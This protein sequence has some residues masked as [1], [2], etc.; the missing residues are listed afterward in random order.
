MRHWV[1]TML[2]LAA[3]CGALAL[4]KY[5]PVEANAPKQQPGPPLPTVTGTPSGPIVTANSDEPQYN[6]RSGPG[7]FYPKIGFLLAGQTAVAK[8]RTPQGEWILIDYQGVA[9]GVGWVYS[10]NLT[11]PPGSGNIPIVEPP[12]T[13][14]PLYTATID[15]TLAAQFI[16]TPVPTRLPTFTP[17][18][19]LAIPTYNAGTKANGAGGGIPVGM[20]IIT[21]GSLGIF[22]GF[23]SLLRGR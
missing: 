9:G 10:P 3:L 11:I 4:A 6:V 17:P 20:V 12:P 13:P 19:P 21:L 15:P 5:I 8:G 2:I 22:L 7:I 14:T 18:P 1:K 23:L 16:V